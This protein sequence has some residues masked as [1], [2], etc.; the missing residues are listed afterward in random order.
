ML[1]NKMSDEEVKMLVTKDEALVLFEFLTRFSKTDK[2]N[3]EHQ[4]EERALWNL[5]SV[6]EKELDEP[7]K[8]NYSQLLQE[9]RERLKDET[10]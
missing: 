9:A 8:S 5:T 1:T 7:F 2:L 10:T 6:L 3:I 4:S